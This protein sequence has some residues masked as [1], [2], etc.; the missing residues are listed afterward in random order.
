MVRVRFLEGKGRCLE[1][2]RKLPAGTPFFR[3]KA[4]CSIAHDKQLCALCSCFISDATAS[5]GDDM[6]PFDSFCSQR[7][8]QQSLDL[9]QLEFAAQSQLQLI[10]QSYSCSLDLVRMVC[11]IICTRANQVLK[12]VPG[13]RLEAPD[14]DIV[15]D[16]AHLSL[17]TAKSDAIAISAATASLLSDNGDFITATFS[18]LQTLEDHMVRIHVQYVAV[19]L[20][21]DNINAIMDPLSLTVCM[22]MC[23]FTSDR[24]IKLHPG[25]MQSLQRCR[26]S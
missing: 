5:C 23:Y 10:A 11:R 17:D 8:L 19:N 16:V 7:C 21:W 25:G 4:I 1:T 15:D 20:L 14:A 22:P 18:G 2:S 26:N 9:F 24:V 6:L 13:S 12:Q 3:E